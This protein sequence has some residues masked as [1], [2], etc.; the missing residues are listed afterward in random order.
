[1]N[2]PLL[3]ARAATRVLVLFAVLLRETVASDRGRKVQIINGAKQKVDVFWVDEAGKLH[4]IKEKL[5][6]ETLELNT[7]V[8]HTFVLQEV[9][10]NGGRVCERSTG[11]EEVGTCKS[12]HVTVGEEEDDQV[13]VVKR[14]MAVEHIDIHSAKADNP[15]LLSDCEAIGKI[16]VDEYAPLAPDEA[17]LLIKEVTEC[18]ESKV[19]QRLIDANE[20][21][22]FESQMR[23]KLSAQLENYTCA[24]DSLSTTAPIETRTW[25]HD[26]KEREVHVLHERKASKIHAI[27]NFITP[28]ECEAI[29]KAAKPKLHR[30][31]V[32]DGKGGSKLSESRKA[33]QAGIRVPWHLEGKGNGI[34]TAS[35]R[36]YDYINEVTGYDMKVDG[37]E[38]LMSI[39]YFGRG[40]DDKEPDRY[41][42]HCD[43]DCGGL[44]HKTGG[45]VATMVMYCEAPESGGAT[46]FQNANV[47]V[48]PE[49]GTA[50]FFS[51]LDLDSNIMDTGLTTHSGCPVIQG[52][53]KIAVQWLR[54]GVD[55]DNPWDSFNTLTVKYEDQDL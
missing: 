33:K 27:K 11:D 51:Y 9:P 15:R 35:R 16:A 39:Q 13:F 40:K 25:M 52:S 55:A 22:T 45:R 24:D 14:G 2:T 28:Q 32:A 38:D 54:I 48:K 1:M 17:A 50:V 23:E 49:V 44:P 41:T 18:M 12:T 21:I 43:G 5:D 53:K 31:T 30:A 36:L 29:E 42:P 3:F 7:F 34:A 46:N 4:L 8:N 6:E 37:Q 10:T 26:G 47:H 20:E 19:V